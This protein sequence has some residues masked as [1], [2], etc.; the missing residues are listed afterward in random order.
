MWKRGSSVAL[1][2]LSHH[3]L[4]KWKIKAKNSE[5]PHPILFS[6]SHLDTLPG[7]EEISLNSPPDI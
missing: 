2:A 6:R 4:F 7:L 1:R 3:L 5:A